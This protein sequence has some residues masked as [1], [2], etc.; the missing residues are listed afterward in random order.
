MKTLTLA[1]AFA[2]AAVLVMASTPAEAAWSRFNVC[3]H[4][5]GTCINTV[6]CW[7]TGTSVSCTFRGTQG[8]PRRLCSARITFPRGWFQT[9]NFWTVGGSWVYTTTAHNQYWAR[10]QW[11]KPKYINMTCR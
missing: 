2:L 8:G 5:K 1:L 10:G 7:R 4:S 11:L 6:Q 3:V 9:S